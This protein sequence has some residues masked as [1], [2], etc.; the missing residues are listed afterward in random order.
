MYTVLYNTLIKLYSLVALFLGYS[1]PALSG[2]KSDGKG[3]GYL[4][5]VTTCLLNYKALPQ[6]SF[7]KFLKLAGSCKR[8]NR[9]IFEDS[10]LG[11]SEVFNQ[12][13]LNT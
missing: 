6:S 1:L 9:G 8:S 4:Q 3:K 7:L 13:C 5:N 2:Q 10:R 11:R 12:P